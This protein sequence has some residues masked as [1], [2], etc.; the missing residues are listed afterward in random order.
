MNDFDALRD[1][2]AEAHRLMLSGDPAAALE[3]LEELEKAHPAS[4]LLWQQRAFCRLACHDG[5]AAEAAFRRAVSLNDAL[6]E[7]WRQLIELARAAGRSAEAIRAARALAKL[8]GLPPELIDG[9][10]RLSEGDLGGAETVI[11]GYLRKHGPHLDGT[12]LLAQVCMHRKNYEDAE[13]LL[14]SVL[15][16]DPDY[17]EARY[18]LATVF[19]QR[20]RIYP[21]LLQA[22]RLLPLNPT[23]RKTRMLYAGA[24]DGLG[25]FDEALRVYRG[26]QAETPGDPDLE[27]AVA[28]VLRNQGKPEEAIAGYRR[29]MRLEGRAGAG[30]AALANLKTYRFSDEEI[31]EM[32]RLERA[33]ESPAQRFPV[34]FALGKALEDRGQYQESFERY[35]QGNALRRTESRYN[36]ETAERNIT[37]REMLFTPE[38]LA[39]RSGMGCPRPD[40]IFIVGMPRA[41]STLLEQVLASHTQVDGTLELPEIPRLVRQF[42]GRSSEDVARHAA[43]LAELTPRELQRL[44][45]IYLEETQVYRERAPFF[46]DKLPANFMEIGFIHLILPNARI[47]DARRDALACCFSNFK[48]LFANGQEFS[49]DLAELGRYYR[50]YVRLMNHWDRVLPGKVL[51]VRH[52]DTVNDFE[53][54]VRRILGHCDLPFEQACLEFYKTERSVRTMSSEQVRRPINREGLEQWRHYEPW[55]GPL[56]EA[57]GPLAEEDPGPGADPGSTR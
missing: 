13:L 47:I 52:A 46:V 41:G 20:R 49:Y 21:A 40:P 48:Q 45:E 39:G 22:Q 12:R 25:R 28:G 50:G 27:F 11:R 32:R 35:A 54:T 18:E 42:R 14:E 16:R 9:S 55:L 57:L 3:R 10:S 15:D 44:G 1:A 7:A 43:I 26:L 2:L 51:H 19:M 56:R 5:A 23:D 34:C 17:H 6:P 24:C 29:A 53:G 38:F 30:Y 33:A 8:D 37:M 36:P 4:G 31:A